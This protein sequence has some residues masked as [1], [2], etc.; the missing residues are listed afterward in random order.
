MRLLLRKFFGA[1]AWRP[2]SI[3]LIT[4]GQDMTSGGIFAI[5]QMAV[6]LGRTI[7]V[8]LVVLGYAPTPVERIKTFRSE[9]LN[10]H[11][12]PD[13]DA[14]VLYSD[15]TLGDQFASLPASKGRKFIYF[16]GYGEIG[17]PVVIENLRRGFGVIASARWLVDEARVQTNSV[18]FVPY[19]LDKS[20]FNPNGR[21]QPTRA[22]AMMTHFL[23]WKGIEDGLGAM[24]RVR[25]AL[26]DVRFIFFGIANP[27]FDGAEFLERPS[28]QGVA[29]IMRKS[30][31]FVCPS[32]EE[33][34]GMPG[35]EAMAC[36]AAL[37]TTDTKGCRDY[38]LHGRTALVSPPKHPDA[39]AR[40][41][42]TLLTDDALRDRIAATGQQTAFT[43]PTWPQAAHLFLQAIMS[44]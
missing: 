21:T 11:E 34:F 39:L 20:I 14:I 26:S 32:W 3:T 9:F 36:G 10:P 35:L 30:D 29:D 25:A 33:G 22:I 37:A 17:N 8:N 4:P 16:Q 24:R 13:A 31:V 12:I 6:E 5:H 15:A 18:S 19:G 44:S 42:I 40:N 43:Y 1:K 23:Q 28:R 2:R 38:A 27:G 7:D 41:I